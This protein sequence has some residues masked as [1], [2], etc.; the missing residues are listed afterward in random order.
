[1]DVVESNL[2]S[3]E[4]MKPD[5]CDCDGVKFELDQRQSRDD[6]VTV[7]VMYFVIST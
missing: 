1:M 3:A 2:P 4:E 6:A 5:D 7:T